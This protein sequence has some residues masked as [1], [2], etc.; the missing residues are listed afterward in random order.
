MSQTQVAIV[1]GSVSDAEVVNAARAVL[2]ELEIP[3]EAKVLSAHR[4]PKEVV[5][6]V[7][8]LPARGCRVIIAGAGMSAHLAGVIAAHTQLPVLGVP[9]ASGALQG[10]DAL[11]STSQ[12][13]PGVPVGT[14][15]IGKA[16]GTNA[17]MLAGRIL[18]LSDNAL[19]GRLDNKVAA[20][21][22]KV[23]STELP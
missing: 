18:A 23:L 9:I 11:L 7:E 15:G 12:M 3:H 21:R 17:A 8:A 10:V 6:Y 5:D 1:V 22:D 19:R 20:M 14:L 13:P 4:T 2:K 16:G